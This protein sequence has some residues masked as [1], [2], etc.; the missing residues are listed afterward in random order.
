MGR[1]TI[2]KVKWT[3]D[4]CGSARETAPGDIST[5]LGFIEIK[6]TFYATEA[7]ATPFEGLYCSYLCA[8]EAVKAQGQGAGMRRPA[9][10]PVAVAK[11]V[12]AEA[13]PAEAKPVA[14]EAKP[15]EAKPGVVEA[16]PAEERESMSPISRVRFRRR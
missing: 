15:A 7:Q 10:A 4:H 6:G 3:C 5:P 11:P 16:K 2:E 14:V 8:S 9:A 13:K 1:Q 12:A